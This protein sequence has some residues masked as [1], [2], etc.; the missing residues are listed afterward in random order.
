MDARK[1]KDQ[2]QIRIF[3]ATKHKMRH[4]LFCIV[5][6]RPRYATFAVV[7]G[8]HGL[9]WWKTMSALRFY[10][11]QAVGQHTTRPA[12]RT[13]TATGS[14]KAEQGGRAGSGFLLSPRPVSAALLLLFPTPA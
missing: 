5:P 13:G 14:R 4:H 9:R 12:W 3:D 7:A 6:S 2:R 8:F 10:V 1:S 11:Q